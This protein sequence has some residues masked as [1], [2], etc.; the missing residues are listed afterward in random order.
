MLAYH[1]S[2][3]SH[4]VG[5]VLTGNGR[6][7]VMEIIEDALEKHRPDACIDRFNAVYAVEHPD[8]SMLGL[9]GGYIH[10]VELVSPG[11]HDAYWVGQLQMAQL[12]IKYGA[13]LPVGMKH[14]PDWTDEFVAECAANYW[15]GVASANPKWEF[16]APSSRVVCQL[17]PDLVSA[18]GT[19][20][21]WIP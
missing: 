12:K 14:L 1:M 15:N 16:L 8:F 5:A 21:G 7:K 18:Q 13:T 10:S 2:M 4:A 20:G 11:K 3:V 17:S 9:D 19:K 6:P